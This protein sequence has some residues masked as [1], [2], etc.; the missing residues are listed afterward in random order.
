M[1]AIVVGIDNSP[2]IRIRF[3]TDIRIGFSVEYF[4]IRVYITYI[5]NCCSYYCTYMQC[6]ARSEEIT[7]N[8]SYVTV[9]LTASIYY[10]RM[11]ITLLH[12]MQVHY[13]FRNELEYMTLRFSTQCAHCL[14]ETKTMT[15]CYS[16][17]PSGE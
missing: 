1:L 6:E 5:I 14:H 2:I 8:I 15:Q 10:A 4:I 13:N 7:C 17:N 11:Q 16:T 3:Y 12:Y 9:C